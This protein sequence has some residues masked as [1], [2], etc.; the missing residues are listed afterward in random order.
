MPTP[1]HTPKGMVM[2]RH[3]V[4][5][6]LIHPG[7]SPAEEAFLADAEVLASSRV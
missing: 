3:T 7:G 4:V 1:G 6:R 5:F 2:I